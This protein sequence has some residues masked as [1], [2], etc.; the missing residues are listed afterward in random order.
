MITRKVNN[1]RPG[2]SNITHLV[3]QPFNTLRTRLVILFKAPYAKVNGFLRIPFSTKIW[4]PH[5]R[6]VFGNKVQFGEGCIINCNI[7]FGNSIL[8]AQNVAFVGRDDHTFNFIG[9]SIWNNPRGDSYQTVIE[10]DVWIGHGAIIIA[11]VRIGKG[12]IVA[13]G[14]VIVKDV[15]PYSIV[16][17][18]PAHFIKN[19]F[20]EYEIELHEK[21]LIV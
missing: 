2:R 20:S 13:A 21:L 8:V 7:I 4:S 3:R 5:K 19:R 1:I 9:S 16:G 14:S 17:G 12:A 6:V 11:G 15:K 18:N 10:D